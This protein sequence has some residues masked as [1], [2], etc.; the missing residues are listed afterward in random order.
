VRRNTDAECEKALNIKINAGSE[1]VLELMKT[2]T[3]FN[4][5]EGSGHKSKSRDPASTQYGEIIK[6]AEQQPQIRCNN[7]ISTIN[8]KSPKHEYG[9]VIKKK[10]KLKH[11]LAINGIV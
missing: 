9:T 8:I 10:K 2:N 4:L 1:A 5:S 7:Q 3:D 11:K 6:S